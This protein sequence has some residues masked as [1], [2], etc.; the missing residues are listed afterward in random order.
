[1]IDSIILKNISFSYGEHKVIDNLN[2]NIKHGSI[3]TLIGKSGVGKSLTL[4]LI[5]A[6][7]PLTSGEIL[8]LPKKISFAFQESP[9]IPWLT[10][11]DNLKICSPNADEI[12][13][14]LSAF[15]LKNISAYYPHELSG[16][17]IQKINIIR[18]FLNSPDL[19]LMDEPFVHIDSIQKEELHKF[20]IALWRKLHPTIIFVTHDIDE[21]IFLSQE[22]SLF[23]KTEKRITSHLQLGDNTSLDMLKLKQSAFYHENFSH[24]YNHLK[25][26]ES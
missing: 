26:D 14:Y 18:S 9:L 19:I 1:M 10:I 12:D 15:E 6:L 13:D 20:L 2:L 24:I 23:G 11:K 16:G 17:M 3:H 22:I 5:S 7:L 21:A 8:N 25:Q 4:K